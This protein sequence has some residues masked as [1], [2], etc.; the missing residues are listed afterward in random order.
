MYPVYGRKLSTQTLGTPI[1][2]VNLIHCR[3]TPTRP[4]S[5]RSPTFV[6]AKYHLPYNC[7]TLFN[8]NSFE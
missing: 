3:L 2:I 8:E 6:S 7:L 5:K 1:I 4:F